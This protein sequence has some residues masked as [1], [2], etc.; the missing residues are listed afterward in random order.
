LQRRV[1]EHRGRVSDARAAEAD[2]HRRNSGMRP[3]FC[4]GRFT[5]P[6]ISGPEKPAPATARWIL[7]Q[8]PVYAGGASVGARA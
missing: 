8:S 6:L 2:L 4:P 5:K 3:R 7:R 1:V